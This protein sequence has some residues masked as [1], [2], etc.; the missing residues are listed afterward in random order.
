MFEHRE[1]LLEE[2]TWDGE[3]IV[4]IK[5]DGWTFSGAKRKD[6][7]CPDED[8]ERRLAPGCRLRFWTIQFSCVAGFEW[9]S[10]SKLGWKAVWYVGNDFQPKAERETASKAYAQFIEDESEVIA[11]L[12]DEGKSLAEID[13]GISDGHSGNTFGWA[14]HLGIQKAKN[15][16]NAERVRST[17]LS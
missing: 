6:F 4:T 16:E 15:R 3:A 1:S 17:R 7:Y 13:A 12:I 8:W 5:S 11:R 14:L 2:I 10:P 9:W